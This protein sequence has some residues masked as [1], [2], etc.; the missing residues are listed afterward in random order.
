MAYLDSG[1]IFWCNV[2]HE[3]MIRFYVRFC[4]RF[5]IGFQRLDLVA[6][7]KPESSAGFM[8]AD[9]CQMAESRFCHQTRES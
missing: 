6:N 2:S 5:G 7:M 1:V 3:T 4:V 9:L 8:P